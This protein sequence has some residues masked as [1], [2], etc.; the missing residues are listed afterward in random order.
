VHDLLLL[1]DPNRE[2]PTG[3]IDPAHPTF[4]VAEGAPFNRLAGFPGTD[5]VGPRMGVAGS[6]APTP[7]L[8]CSL[9]GASIAA[10]EDAHGVSVSPPLGE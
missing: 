1:V 3:E 6:A 2:D 7:F 9:L 4:M 10:V 8:I 5:R